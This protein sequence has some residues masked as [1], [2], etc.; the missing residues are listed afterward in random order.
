MLGCP[1]MPL[2][3]ARS[4]LESLEDNIKLWKKGEGRGQKE[5]DREGR[6]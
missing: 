2:R 6:G 1:F 5:E 3:L 4:P